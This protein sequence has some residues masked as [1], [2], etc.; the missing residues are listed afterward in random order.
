MNSLCAYL[1]VNDISASEVCTVHVWI[2]QYSDSHIITLDIVSNP[3]YEKVAKIKL[4]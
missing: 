1:L 2:I 3:A 4:Y